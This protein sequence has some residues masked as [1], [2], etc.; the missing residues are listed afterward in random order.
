MSGALLGSLSCARCAQI[1]PA[2]DLFCTTCGAR[3]YPAASGGALSQTGGLLAG[4]VQA[5]ASRK[6]AALA[7][8]AGAVLLGA[9]ILAGAAVGLGLAPGKIAVVVGVAIL[10]A[11]VVATVLV[12]AVGSTGRTLGMRLLELRHVDN[13]TALPPGA[14]GALVRSV[15]RWRPRSTL[16][17]DLRRG[18][19]PLAPAHAQTILAEQ[20]LGSVHSES[21]AQDP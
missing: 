1:L 6:Q 13:L 7:L 5:T 9:A 21:L 17:A 19:D 11:V 15:A 8:D 18:R 2:D 20:T 10:G 3:Q 12:L 14:V 16:T 4:V